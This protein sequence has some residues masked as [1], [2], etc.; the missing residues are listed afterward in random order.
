MILLGD[1]QFPAFEQ[2]LL[3]DYRASTNIRPPTLSFTAIR[4]NE[5]KW[6]PRGGRGTP[7]RQIWL[8]PPPGR[9]SRPRPTVVCLNS[10]WCAIIG[11]A[12]RNCSRAACCRLHTTA[13]AASR[14]NF[15]EGLIPTIHVGGLRLCGSA[16]RYGR[17]QPTCILC[18]M[19]A[20]VPLESDG[21]KRAR[22]NSV[23]TPSDTYGRVSRREWGRE[24]W[25][26]RFIESRV[27][28]SE[29]E[30]ER[31]SRYFDAISVTDFTDKS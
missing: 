20:C 23:F 26:P 12:R 19:R 9:V 15:P 21:K 11:D 8:F 16:Y 25:S 28:A 7:R 10:R 13:A 24:S 30:T 2:A 29:M 31:G 22:V 18:T 17:W 6:L 14:K 5:G 4:L 27:Y 1:T 3:P